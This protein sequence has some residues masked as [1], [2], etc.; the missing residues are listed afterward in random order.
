MIHGFLYKQSTDVNVALLITKERGI[1]HVGNR[2]RRVLPRSHLE[3]LRG[4]LG[5]VDLIDAPFDE[6]TPACDDV[7]RDAEEAK[8]LERAGLQPRAALP[9][10]VLGVLLDDAHRHAVL[11]E[12]ER[13]HEA[14]WT[15]ASL[16]RRKGQRAEE[17]GRV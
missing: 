1:A 6:T 3:D 4:R 15:C 11:C 14:G 13:E 9:D 12:R 10:V 5:V 7:V 2:R 8:H 17:E 16:Q